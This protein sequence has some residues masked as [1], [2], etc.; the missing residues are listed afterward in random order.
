MKKILLFIICFANFL[1]AEPR[2]E[3]DQ[4]ALDEYVHSIDES[5]EYKLIKTISGEGYKTYIVDLTSQSYLTKNDID[6]TEWKHWLIIVS[7]DVIKHQTGMLV[8][9]AGDNDGKIPQGP[10][11]LSVEYAKATNSVVASLGMVPNQPLTFSGETKP[12]WEDAIIAYTWDKYFTTGEDRWPLRMAMTK[13]AVSAMDAI[14]LIIEDMNGTKI[15]KFVV[16]GA[17]KRGWTTW[18]TGGVDDRVEAIIPVV[19]DLLNLEPSFEHH[20]SAYGFWAPAIQDYVDMEIMDWWGTKEMKSLFK[21]VD[22]FNVKE[23]FEMPKLL[24][25]AAGDQFFIPTSSQFYFDELPGEKYLRYVPNADH[26]VSEGTDALETILAFYASIL[27]KVPRPEFS[28][29]L[30]EDGSIEVLSESQVKEVMMWS[31][32][33]D[34]RRD[35]RKDTIGNSWVSETLK[36]NEEGSYIA[37]PSTPK[38]GWKAYF[39]EMTYETPFGLDL[40]LTTPVR[41]T[42]DTLPYEYKKPEKPKKGFLSNLN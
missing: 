18:T 23:R 12:R 33:N 4:T 16:S 21:L 35:F 1:F 29:N 14:Q 28:W 30:N 2:L 40:K 22:P 38:E 39:V 31:A 13:S 10:D 41:V 5:F 7:P 9:G 26:N 27:N 15:E 24:V 36:Q 3:F 32:T 11:Q 34:K 19:I 20:W 17:S 37:L 8:I 42:P 25:N 6:R